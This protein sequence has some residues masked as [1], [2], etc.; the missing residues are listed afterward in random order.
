MRRKILWEEK[1]Y[2]KGSMYHEEEIV[3]REDVVRERNC[4]EKICDKNGLP[5]WNWNQN[6]MERERNLKK[7][8]YETV[9]EFVS[10]QK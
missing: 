5:E 2:D 7:M 3:K 6:P 9:P 1:Y 8:T 10:S 4:Y